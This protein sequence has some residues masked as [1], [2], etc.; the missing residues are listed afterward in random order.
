M[1]KGYWIPHLDVRDPEG[2]KAYMAATPPAHHKYTGRALVRGGACEVVEGRARSRNVLREFPD[3]AT[4]L[5]CYRSPEY[6]R[7]KPLRLPHSECDFVIIE[8]YDGPQ[9]LQ[10]AVPAST[11]DAAAAR[12]GYWIGHV[13]VI[14]PEAYKA[15]V[16]ANGVA[17]GKFGGRFL[18]RG[19]TREVVEG[20]VRG[21]TVVLEFPSYRAALDCYRS[22]DYT[23]AAALRQGKAELDLVIVEGYDGPQT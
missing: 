1:A 18:V 2:Y 4:A 3:Y 16:A 5:A 6:Q 17:F 22:P 15:Y 20:K 12:K 9:P 10:P 11:R 21:R 8:G 23:A 13:D 14:D 7:A 19:G